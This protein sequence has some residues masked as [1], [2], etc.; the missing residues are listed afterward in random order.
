MVLDIGVDPSRVVFNNPF[1]EI[2][3]LKFSARHGVRLLTANCE[4]ELH[5]IKKYHPSAQ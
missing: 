1:K 5:K 3:H 4:M 2:S